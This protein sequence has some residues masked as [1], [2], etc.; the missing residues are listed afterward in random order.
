MMFQLL[1]G[2]GVIPRAWRHPVEGRHHR[3]NKR[4]KASR[5]AQRRARRITRLS[6]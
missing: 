3:A 5:K 2:V 1:P 6:K 4:C